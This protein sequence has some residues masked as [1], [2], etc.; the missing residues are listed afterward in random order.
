MSPR[1]S[2]LL[3]SAMV[4]LTQFLSVTGDSNIGVCYGL[5]GDN[6]PSPTDVINLYKSSQIGN[7][8]LYQPYPEV[9]EALRGSGLAVAIGPLN[10]D[11]PNLA[12][13]QNAANAWVNTNIVPYKDDVDFK[14]ITIGNEVIP[15]PLASSVPGA[16]NNILNALATA[17]LQVMVTTVVSG[18]ALGASYPPSAGAFSSDTVPTMTGVAAILAQ[19]GAPLMANLYPYFAYASDP[20]HISADYALFASSTPVVIDAGLDYYNLFDA[21]VDAFNSALEK[22]NFG[23]VNIAVAETG[24]PTVGNEPYTSV[25]NAQTYN[26]NLM[27]HVTQSGSPKKPEYIMTVFYFEMFNEDLKPSAV[28]QNFGFFYPTMQPVYPFW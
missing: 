4:F 1:F 18:S 23:N 16:M 11:I 22:I 20:T 25:Q 12:A 6:L 10:N 17:G 3:V 14:W 7:L 2:G 19:Q 26:K 27:N 13:D 5:N 8:R 9:L 15:G 21:M 28:E 24:W